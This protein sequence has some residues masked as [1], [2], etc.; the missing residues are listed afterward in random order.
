MLFSDG[1][2]GYLSFNNGVVTFGDDKVNDEG[3]WLHAEKRVC[4]EGS[5]YDK[6][7]DSMLGAVAPG[8][9][10]AATAYWQGKL[11]QNAIFADKDYR[12]MG[13]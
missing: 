2:N 7:L 5:V 9:E 13:E 1:M 10:E 11:F 12:P 6:A 8:A 3:R 4:P